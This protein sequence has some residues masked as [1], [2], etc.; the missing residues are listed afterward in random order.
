L[1]QR[2]CLPT[3]ES[4]NPQSVER[5]GFLY[6]KQ[7]PFLT[8]PPAASA[9]TT[10]RG[11]SQAT[12]SLVHLAQQLLGQ[13]LRTGGNNDDDSGSDSDSKPRKGSKKAEEP[14]AVGEGVHDSREDACAAIDLVLF[15]MRREV[16]GQQTGLLDPPGV[17]VGAVVWWEWDCW[18]QWCRVLQGCLAA[19]GASHDQSALFL[20]TTH[21][22]LLNPWSQPTLLSP[23]PLTPKN[24][25][26]HPH[27][28]PPQVA[29]PDLS[30]LLIH[31]IP[32]TLTAPQLAIPHAF[33]KAGA[34]APSSV[35]Q[36]AGPGQLLL[37]FANPAVANEAFAALPGRH[38]T[39]SVG[40]HQKQLELAGG[41]KVGLGVGVW[42][43]LMEGGR[44]GL[45][46]G[47]AGCRLL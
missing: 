14:A 42:T 26:P 37:V 40:R 24:N 27:P 10:T 9:T 3:S 1:T 17:K 22:G 21:Q 13:S 38:A 15:E 34:P 30:K 47:W 23:S 33:G 5:L 44:S 46:S 45:R 25:H 12:P 43:G 11:L 18:C 36:T 32:P 4:S 35:E 28:T 16:E 7:S 6:S 20:V 29:K 19:A 8:P 31:A 39:D 41:V 2:F